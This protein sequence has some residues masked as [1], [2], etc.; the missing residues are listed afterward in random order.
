MSATARERGENLLLA[1]LA[2]GTRKGRFHVQP[3]CSKCGPLTNSTQEVQQEKKNKIKKKV[4]G[5]QRF[6]RSR[7]G[8]IFILK[9][10]MEICM[11]FD[12]H[13]LLVWNPQAT[14]I[15]RTLD[16]FNFLFSNIMKIK[17]F[18]VAKRFILHLNLVSFPQIR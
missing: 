7:L 3:C 9:D 12:K 4:W 17:F 1:H 16:S 6:P 11:K 14:Y 13:C 2:P 15:F 10:S 5:L 18:N 8:G